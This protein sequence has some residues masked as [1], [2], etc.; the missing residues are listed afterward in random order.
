M[1]TEERRQFVRLDTRL[2]I[3]YT[4]LPSGR[5]QQT[6]AKNVSGDGVCLFLKQS[7]PQGT[8][9]QVGMKLPGRQEPAHFTAEVIW[10]ETYE[11]IGKTER[12]RAVEAGVRFVEIS[13]ADREAIMQ[14]V[15]LQ[16]QPD[17]PTG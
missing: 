5:V 1:T 4:V 8:R 16:L 14:H 12:Q 7:V 3:T 15:I 17:R 10:C 11:M 9:L 6:A 2:D 13:P